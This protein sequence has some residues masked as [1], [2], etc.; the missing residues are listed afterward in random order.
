MAEQQSSDHDGKLLWIAVKNCRGCSV[1]LAVDSFGH[2]TY[3]L[4]PEEIDAVRFALQFVFAKEPPC[5]GGAC[6]TPEWQSM[7]PYLA[8]VTSDCGMEVTVRFQSRS[9]RQFRGP[10]DLKRCVDGSGQGQLSLSDAEGHCE[11]VKGAE[12]AIP[13]GAD[14]LAALFEHLGIGSS[15]QCEHLGIFSNAIPGYWKTAALMSAD[16]QELYRIYMHLTGLHHELRRAEQG[17]LDLKRYYKNADGYCARQC[18]NT[19]LRDGHGYAGDFVIDHSARLLRT[20][21]SQLS[22]DREPLPQW[23]RNLALFGAALAVSG[24]P[25]AI[26]EDACPVPTQGT[27]GR[28]ETPRVAMDAHRAHPWAVVTGASHNQDTQWVILSAAGS[29]ERILR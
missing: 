19:I 16:E 4:A 17:G 11:T 21:V 1:S 8:A 5:C 29:S 3:P 14:M 7:L 13:A 25:F 18:F 15:A 9:Y 10:V 28:S 20:E 23:A 27:A 26:Q 24:V 2:K 6:S 22:N 12:A